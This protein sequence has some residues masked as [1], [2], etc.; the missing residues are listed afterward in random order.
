V[1][2]SWML[3]LDAHNAPGAFTFEKISA[4]QEVVRVGRSFRD[5]R[6]FRHIKPTHTHA[7]FFL[8]IYFFIYMLFNFYS[9]YYST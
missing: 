9:Q 3:A 4:R 5:C 2:R 1:A 6:F 7:T 8:N